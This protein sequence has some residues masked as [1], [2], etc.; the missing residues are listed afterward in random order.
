MPVYRITAPNGVT[1]ETVGPPGATPE[2][3]KAVIL[4]AH[5]EAAVPPQ[6]ESALEQIPLVGGVLGQVADYPAAFV[7]GL[8][9]V[10]KAG[11]DVFGADNAVSGF[12]GDVAEGAKGMRSK[13]SRESEMAR[14]VRSQ[15]AEKEGIGAQLG[16][17]LQNFSE[18]P[19]ETT[20]SVTG[21]AAPFIAAG[22]LSGGTAVPAMLGLGVGAGTVKGAI[23]DATYEEFKAAGANEEQ[24]KAAA[25]QAQTYTG[26]NAD[27]IGIGAFLGGIASRF[28][29]EPAIAQTIGRQGAARVAS[30]L[31]AREAAE[32]AGTEIGR[33]S[34]VRGA[35]SGAAKEAVPEA[36]QGGQE[37]YAANLALQRQGFDVDPWEGVAGQA[38]A[39]GLASLL[40]GAFGGA[41]ETSI[42]NQRATAQQYTA[43]V[44]A[45]P[46]APTEEDIAPIAQWAVRRGFSE[47]EAAIIAKNAA[48][49]RQ[50]LTRVKAEVEAAQQEELLNRTAGVDEEVVFAEPPADAPPID[51]E[52]E[53]AREAFYA[54]Q[55]GGAPPVVPPMED[56]SPTAQLREQLIPN[57]PQPTSMSPEQ[58]GMI[59]N[60]PVALSDYEASG[61]DVGTLYDIAEGNIQSISGR[62][63]PQRG[64]RPKDTET[65]DMFG[66]L[67]L[68]EAPGIEAKREELAAQRFAPE[69]ERAALREQAVAEMEAGQE[70]VLAMRQREEEQRDETLGDIEYALRAQ[71]PENAVYKVEYDPEDANPYRLVAETQLG[72][73]PEEVLKAKTLQEFSDQV[74]GRMMELTPYIPPAPAAIQDIEERESGEL[75]SPTV[76]TRMVQEFTAEVDAAREAGLIDNLQRSELLGRLE[77]PGAYRTLP[78][79]RQAPADAI[80]KLEKA[81]QDAAS[82]ANNASAEEQDAAIAAAKE[83]NDRLAAAVQNS[84]LNPARAAL[85]SMVEMR[86]D[87]KLGARIRKEQAKVQERLGQME[88]GDTKAER[89][90]LRDAKIDL[91]QL[92][93]SSRQQGKIA[94][95]DPRT[96]EEVASETEGM[97]ATEVVDW[98]VD[99]APNPAFATIARGV[100]N[101]MRRLARFGY[102]FDFQVV[103]DP[104]TLPPYAKQMFENS[105]MGVATVEGRNA[106]VYVNPVMAGDLT[107]MRYETILHEFI[108]VV[109]VPYLKM[110]AKSGV[111]GTRTA[112]LNQ[113]LRDVLN[114]IQRRMKVRAK[115]GEELTPL[116]KDVLDGYSN[117]FENEYELLAWALSNPDVMEYLN[118]VPYAGGKQTVFQRFIEAVRNILGLSAKSDSALAEVLRIGNQLLYTGDV[119]TARLMTNNPD[120]RLSYSGAQKKVRKADERLSVGARRVEKSFATAPMLDGVEEMTTGHRFKDWAA[121]LKDNWSLFSPSKKQSILK[122]LPSSGI[123]GWVKPNNKALHAAML[124]I[125]DRV[126]KMNALKNRI[127]AASDE[128][129]REIREFNDEHGTKSLAVLQATARINE[130]DP[131]AFKT[132]EDALKGDAV[133]KD[134]EA[135]LLKGSNNR[136]TAQQLIDDIKAVVMQ[137]K[138]SVKVRGDQYTMSAALKGKVK[139]LQRAA[140]GSDEAERRA[141]QLAEMVR[142]IRDTYAARAELDK[143]KGGERIYKEMRQFYKDMF[144]AE[145]ALLEERINTVADEEEA[146]RIKDMRAKLMREAVSPEERKK[147]GDLFWD[148]DADLFTK[149]YFPF[150]REG[151]RW[152]RVIGAKDGT[153]E[154]EFHTFRTD[155]ELRAAQKKIAARL[156]VDPNDRS[157]IQIGYDIARLQEHLRGEDAL[158]QRVFDAVGKARE[159]YERSG[160]INLKELT[161]AIYQTWLMTTPERSVRRRLMHAEEVVGFSPDVFLHFREQATAYANQLSK[162]A[163]A[164]KIRLAV[165]EAREVIN[166]VERPADE[167]AD[168]NLFVDEF[169][170]RANS[171][172]NPEPQN[173]IVNLLNRSSYYYY[174]TSAKTAILQTLTIP[175]RVVPRLWR[176]Y[177]YAKGTAMWLKYMQMWNSLGRVKV[178]RGKTTYGDFIDGI[179]PSINGSQFIK[180]S[181]DL[182]WAKRIGM[183]RGILETLHDTLVQNERA[184]P[185]ATSSGVRKVAEDVG[186]NVGKT[187]SFLFNGMENISRQAAYY[188]TFELALEKYRSEN[189][190]ASAEEARNYAFR[191]AMDVLRNTAGDFS[192]WERPTLAKGNLARA[193]FLFKMHPI[194]QT[195]FM[196]GAVRDIWTNADN[197]RRGA[198]KELSGVLMMTGMLGG[199]MGMPLYS[200]MTYALMAAFGPDPDDDEDVIALMGGDPRTAYDPDIFF[201]SWMTDKFGAIE[202]AG[203]PL[204]EI[205]TGGLVGTALDTELSSS[206]SLDLKNMWFRDAV[207]G[208]SLE[209]TM[210]QTAVANIAGFSMVAQLM[211][212][213]D[214]FSE[215]KIEDGLK[216]ALPAFFR[217]WVSAA[218]NETQGVKNRR[219]DVLIPK[220]DIDAADNFRDVLGFRAPKL[221]RIQQYYIT[222]AKNET[223]IK[224]ER[225]AILD[226]LETAI[227]NGEIATQAAYE[228]FRDE[229]ITPFN[230]TYPDSEFVITDETVASSIKRRAGIRARTIEGVQFDKKTA[231]KDVAAQERFV[232]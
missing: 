228:E 158:M 59:L 144:D 204:S 186:A 147:G 175:V 8:A 122:A 198:L 194:T 27:Q 63:F 69:E 100:R 106:V 28:G 18:A 135:K 39:E 114:A 47:E 188:M 170:D 166:D 29:F 157:V 52:E 111:G 17:A 231:A 153:R 3:I 211:R 216:K 112:K 152:L 20:A 82:A 142:R 171:E 143:L 174:L 159:R 66:A 160:N 136:A 120:Y 103:S 64:R 33:R 95:N 116:E 14:A 222:R 161:D 218:V 104:E 229:Y 54:E 221:S 172:M 68:Q 227:G 49:Q 4:K 134:I 84:L 201:R 73:K 46:D 67:P 65:V 163:Y 98:L 90:E 92:K 205:L 209:D 133:L 89:A 187:M 80:A 21:S 179:M 162:L 127:I 199:V 123:L 77:R 137:N 132:V 61:G 56:I 40:P 36:M 45:L 48:E 101:A 155:A 74:Y 138:D 15:L 16:A 167:A 109:T 12:F 215:G 164:G 94:Q 34:L 30:N 53:A 119:E 78:N 219:G 24:A 117:V 192:T 208:D 86:K 213:Y 212:S 55:V 139:L 151:D 176:D 224:A 140:K 178:E 149:D 126:H 58:A 169:E 182:Q 195:R 193:V 102:K 197:Q 177:G 43:Q 51:P 130:Q 105:A 206:T 183:E 146:I 214:S 118:T 70:R 223:A 83:A 145:L 225:N 76:A 185:G 93:V 108:H 6:E 50:R 2:Q 25:E 44:E 220:S 10:G 37:R 210:L 168:L 13:E 203:M 115:V 88:E 202:V 71:A 7:E 32:A 11:A 19:L 5:P 131:Y 85:K 91:E 191:Q 31:A 9:S 22:V 181:A 129:A 97:S 184:T 207:V 190:K 62:A 1:Y 79:G 107:G 217:T 57:I 232:Q 141:E 75:D 125:D 81:A 150:M 60:D 96:P 87:E 72:K 99:T 226:R 124:E 154:R 180:N 196:V 38:A 189:K 113:D 121:A 148:I 23:Y 165:D 156:G 26:E 173:A 41:R 110:A 128:L 42:D 230:R 35:A 200:A